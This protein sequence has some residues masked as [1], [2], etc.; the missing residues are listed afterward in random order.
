MDSEQDKIRVHLRF[1]STNTHP[2][3]KWAE[4]MYTGH[5]D[6]FKEWLRN[7]EQEAWDEG[8]FLVQRT[9]YLE[10]ISEEGLWKIL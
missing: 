8:Y 10:E 9:D 3:F 5:P 2:P 7:I 1:R 4:A 6:N